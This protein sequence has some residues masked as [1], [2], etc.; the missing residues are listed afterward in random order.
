MNIRYDNLENILKSDEFINEYDKYLNHIKYDKLI[1][2]LDNIENN[3]NYYHLNV[4]K[5]NIY[6]KSENNDTII[7]KKIINLINKITD[8]TF[9]NIKIEII[10]Q[11]NDKKYLHS[12]IIENIIEISITNSIYKDLG[13]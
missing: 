12:M 6:K 9:D 11:I 7:L 8:N 1:N 3:K 5:K 4:N 2:F 10:K 13:G